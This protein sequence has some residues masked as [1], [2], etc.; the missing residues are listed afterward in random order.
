M[1]GISDYFGQVP[2]SYGPISPGTG[3][4]SSVFGMHPSGV[5]YGIADGS[6]KNSYGYILI[7]I[8]VYFRL[9]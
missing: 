5:L 3:S 4:E 9:M 7:H 8:R 2:D 6:I 1:H